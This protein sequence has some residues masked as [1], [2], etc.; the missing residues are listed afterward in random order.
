VLAEAGR[1]AE[2]VTCLERLGRIADRTDS[3][4]A[5][6]RYLVASARVLW[7]DACDTARGNLREAVDLARS[8]GL[9]FETATTLVAAADTGA[10]PV[11]LLHEAYE[12]FG[13][14]G[15]ALWRFH[16]RTAIREAGLTGP[17]RKQATSENEHLLA[18]LI[19]EG[20]TNRQIA[21]VLRLS[22][23]AVAQ[24]LS[25]LFARTGLR[26]RTEVVTAVITGSR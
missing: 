1:T 17:G 24:R 25:R 23:D 11:T 16:T 18:T 10:G 21:T 3:G 6:L 8:R 26:S 2:A 5:Q 12:L 20:L 22:E 9:P 7:R 15:A 4:R 14:T 13:V 19:A